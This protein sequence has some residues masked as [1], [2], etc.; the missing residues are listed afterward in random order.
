M[1]AACLWGFGSTGNAIGAEQWSVRGGWTQIGFEQAELDTMG[2]S[3]KLADAPDVPVNSLRLT[4]GQ[5]ATLDA[6][7][8]GPIFEG[9]TEGMIVHDGGV[10]ITSI[11]GGQVLLDGFRIR[12][13]KDAAS[14]FEVVTSRGR[15]DVV[16]LTIGAAR[17]GYDQS[18]RSLLIETADLSPTSELAAA[19]GNPKL[20]DRPIGGLRTRAE[21]TWVGGD[22]PEPVKDEP[23]GGV[24]GGNNGT[25]CWNSGDPLIGPDVIV[26][27]IIDVSNYASDGTTEAFA[28]GTT[29]AT[30]AARTSRGKRA[31]TRIT[32]SSGRTSSG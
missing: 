14:G 27:D 1:F 20:V 3:I 13:A 2:L 24:A 12:P 23:L 26:G 18:M 21:L 31:R 11:D 5:A 6:K 15:D 22:Q 32:R 17:V 16:M 28:L 7:I 30:S 9:I 10:L 4:I 19:L 8:T 25:N 29:S